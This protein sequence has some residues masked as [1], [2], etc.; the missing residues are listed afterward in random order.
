MV[1]TKKREF[2]DTGEL[3]AEKYL[4]SSGY[5][6]LGRNYQI[7]H[8]GE[9]DIIGQK[10]DILIFFEVKT[11]DVTHETN[12]PIAFS[13]SFKKRKRLRRICEIYVQ[14]NEKELRIK[15]WRVDA[16]LISVNKESNESKLEHIENILWERYY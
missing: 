7:A 11:R 3:A 16:I 4:I 6:I 2:G 10:N 13:I 12:F 5:K 8:I 1:K 14:E 15:E 9:I